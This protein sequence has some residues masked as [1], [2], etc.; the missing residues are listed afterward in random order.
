MG[1]SEEDGESFALI[2]VAETNRGVTKFVAIGNGK[3]SSPEK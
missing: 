2:H 3:T 1:G